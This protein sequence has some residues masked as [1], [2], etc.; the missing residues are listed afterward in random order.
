MR[1]RWGVTLTLAIGAAMSVGGSAAWATDPVP[2][3]SSYVL[4]DSD[5]LTPD[6][7]TAADQR[8]VQLR[9]ETGLD[10]WVVFVDDFT[11]PSDS[12]DWANT[13]AQDNGLGPTQYLLAVATDARQYYVSGDSEG[14]LTFDQ[15]AAIEQQNIQPALRNDDWAGAIDAAADG[16]TT[17]SLGG[18][19]GESDGSG[20]GIPGTGTDTGSTGSGWFFPVLLGIVVVGG[21]VFLIVWLARRRRGASP[22]AGASAGGAPQ[23]PIEQL[24]KDAA[25]ALIE[26]DDAIKTS[27]Q[28]LGFAKA[29]FGDQAA[30]AFETAIAQARESLDAAFT[31]KQQL[32]DEI[33]DAAADTRAWNE[34]IIALC[35]EANAGLDAKAAEFDALRE[36]ERRA[37]EALEQ[38]T[39]RRADVAGDL[40]AATAQLAT[41]QQ[42]Y[43]PE[44]LATVADNPEQAATR[45]A[46]A[47]EQIAAAQAALTQGSPSDAAVSIRAAEDAVGQAALLE[48]AIVTLARDLASAEQRAAAVLAELDADVRA[49]AALPDEGGQVAAAIAATTHQM[50]VARAQL[51]GSARRPLL[52]LQSLE[53]A[54]AHIDAVTQGVR[55]AA[56]QAQRAR[57]HVGELILQAQAQ[58]SAAEDYITA[59]RGAV[60]ADARTRLAEAGASLARASALQNSDPEQALQHAHRANQL[61]AQASQLAQ[62]DVGAFSSSPMGTGSNGGGNMM[63][64]VLGGIVI[65]SLLGGG[66]GGGSARRSSGFGGSFGGG[67]RRSGGMRAGSFGGGGTRARRGGGRF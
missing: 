39:Q 6:E 67:S 27:V 53:Q 59:R 63:G 32:D 52:A 50:G 37:P 46:F 20:T 42:S 4:D 26:T 17:A 25:S 45:I 29:Q 8:L 14:P 15:L 10:L 24:E 43:A 2:L 48:E 13:T 23:V 5:V 44:A 16:F 7:E 54:N 58:V 30:A 12:A 3:G 34:R 38:V 9:E 28:E 40:D 47:D 66:G 56:A 60:G 22:A 51:E 64:A 61:A 1:T 18:D 49:A 55:D 41:L 33:P 21:V 19:D 36:L 35:E 62:R 57:A 31:L 65:N 11:N